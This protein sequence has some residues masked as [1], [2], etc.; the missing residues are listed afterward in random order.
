MHVEVG[1]VACE[2]RRLGASGVLAL[3]C[4]LLGAAGAAAAAPAPE[5][6]SAVAPTAEIVV[7]H[8]RVVDPA[9]DPLAAWSGAGDLA[10]RADRAH[11]A[12]LEVGVPSFDAPARAL[13]L[14]PQPS[15]GA[16]ERARAA[17]IV[18]PR[19]PL[20]QAALASALLWESH[21]VGGATAAAWRALEALGEHPEARPWLEAN[22]LLVLRNAL[23]FGGLAFLAGLAALHARAAAHDLGDRVSRALPGFARTAL[24][25]LA[26]LAPAILGQGLLGLALSCFTIALCYG[27]RGERRTA[28]VAA[29]LLLVG[30]ALGSR[31]AARAALVFEPDPAASAFRL[32]EGGMASQGER[33]RLESASPSDELA[34]RALALLA[35]REGRLAEAAQRYETLLASGHTDA[36]LANNAGNVWLAVGNVDRAV[37]RYELAAQLGASPVVLYNLAYGY[38]QAIRP[39]AQDETLQR[40]QRLDPVLAFDLTQLQAKIA[41][42]FTLDLPMPPAALQSRAASAGA[43]ESVAADLRR[44]LAP[45]V[46]GSDPAFAVAAFVVAAVVAQTASRQFR[47]S[48]DCRRC[49]ARLC[50]RCDGVAPARDLCGACHRLFERPETTDPDRRMRRLAELERRFRWLSRA[51]LAASVALPGAAG[52]LAQRPWLGLAGAVSFCAAVAVA[53]SSRVGVVD[54]LA[55]GGAGTLAAVGLAALAVGLNAVVCALALQRRPGTNG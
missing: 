44:P 49:G 51:R 22:G 32:V 37:A 16:L 39:S 8:P 53:L 4:A 19:L 3:V 54:P 10:T 20:A 17:T 14:D 34:A 35:R 36:S 25:G 28:W 24:L 31:G 18:A 43:V 12:A 50:P 42:G 13:L 5:V 30:F 26:V 38:G 45:G 27:S 11:Q 41:G 40:L 1:A 48:S 23:F 55:A 52:L 47:A 15:A 6:P 7:S 29:T 9:P 46:L 2:A 21:D 33:L